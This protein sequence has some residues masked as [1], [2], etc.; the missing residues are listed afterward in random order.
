MTIRGVHGVRLLA[1]TG[2]LAGLLTGCGIRATQVPTDFGPAPSMVPC[3]LSTTDLQTQATPSGMPVEVF[4]LCSGALVRVNRS[5]QVTEG[6]EEAERRVAVAQ[7]LLDALAGDPSDVEDE[8]GYSTAVPPGLTVT[9]PSPGDPEDTL[10]L[11]TAPDSLPKYA[12]AQIVCTF[13]DSAAAGDNGSVVLGSTG[14]EAL[15]RYECAQETQSAP[16][17]G[18][19]PSEEINGS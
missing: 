3:E 11:S 10:R 17:E 16:G 18:N 14:A 2:A 13:A 12:L 9:G 19:P 1:A 6:A 8:A 15:R 5:V 4:L 7:G